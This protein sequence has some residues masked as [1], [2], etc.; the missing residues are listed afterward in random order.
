MKEKVIKI[1]IPE[2]YEID[3]E[4][5]T[6]ER[7]V[8]KLK[9]QSYKSIYSIYR[10]LFYE[11]NTYY[12]NKYGKIESA[13]LYAKDYK[14]L[15]NCTS[16]KQAKKLIAINQLLNVAKYLND[17]WKPD[18][19]DAGKDKFCITL[20]YKYNKMSIHCAHMLSES[21]VYFKTKELAEQAIEILGVETIKLA[22]S[23]DW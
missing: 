18:W 8:F 15:N 3:K 9:E 19:K 13:V 22:L 1:E 17:D 21:I 2:G 4:K 10:K 11:Q 20:N 23:T 12:L 6:F 5:S 14:D 7:V 16:E